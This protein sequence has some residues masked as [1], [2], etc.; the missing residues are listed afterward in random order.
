MVSYRR[1][2]VG[3]GSGKTLCE[4]LTVVDAMPLP[5]LVRGSTVTCSGTAPCCRHF[6]WEAT[7][8]G[9][10]CHGVIAMPLGREA[11]WP[12]SINGEASAA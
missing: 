12:V 3:G 5:I 7:V 8:S 1:R 4:V 2:V 11:D 9:A 6:S 10:D